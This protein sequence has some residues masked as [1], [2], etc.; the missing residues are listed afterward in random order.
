M[1]DLIDNKSDEE[2]L[3]SLIAE[4]AKA[5]NELNCCQNDIK[6]AKNRLSFLLMVA[7]KLIDRQGDSK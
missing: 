7:N 6:K 1:T 2:L 3:R 5:M 4:A